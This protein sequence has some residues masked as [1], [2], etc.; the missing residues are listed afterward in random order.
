MSQVKV[1]GCRLPNGLLISPDPMDRTKRIMINGMN[2]SIIEGA[3]FTTTIV[4]ANMW[5]S[6]VSQNKNYAPLKN[7]ALF[8]AKDAKDAE[9]KALDFITLKTG[10]E[11]MSK[12]AK[13]IKPASD[14]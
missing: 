13:D 1:I 10:F 7:G 4:D 3:K 11:G 2:K 9:A 12:V 5:D 14:K 8:E 6:F